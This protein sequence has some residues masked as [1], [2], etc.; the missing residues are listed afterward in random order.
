MTAGHPASEREN[1]L[2]LARALCAG[3]RDAIWEFERRFVAS[4]PS[5]VQTLDPSPAFADEVQQR[6]RAHLLIGEPGQAPRIAAYA[7]RGSLAGFVRVTAMRIALAL[8]RRRQATEPLLD[9]EDGLAVG[10]DPELDYL[11]AR[12]RPIFTRVFRESVSALAQRER[13][14]LRLSYC[15]GLSASEIARLRQVHVSTI[16]RQLASL[17]DQLLRTIEARLA[18]ALTV[19]KHEVSSLLRLVAGSLDATLSSIL[20]EPSPP[21]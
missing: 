6:L 1:D 13:T 15:D 18:Q 20:R 17:R 3:D 5:Q 7:G 11:K 10:V 8:L 12:Y 16:S 14:L 2:A 4:V 21:A 9:D 19:P